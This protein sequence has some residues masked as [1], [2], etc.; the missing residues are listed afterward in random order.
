M[1]KFTI[2]CG[3]AALVLSDD[4]QAFMEYRKQ[5]ARKMEKTNV[6]KLKYLR[7]GQ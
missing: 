3:A 6:I 1:V 5:E 7:A 2:I 4:W